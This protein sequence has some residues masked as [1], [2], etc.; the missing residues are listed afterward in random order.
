MLPA[1]VKLCCGIS[2]PHLR[3]AAGLQR[4]AVAVIG[5]EVSRQQHWRNLQQQT[6]E[7]A[8][9]SCDSGPSLDVVAKKEHVFLEQQGRDAMRAALEMLEHP[10]GWEVE[11]SETNGDRICSKLMPDARKV[12]RLDVVLDANMEEIYELL[13]VQVEQMHQWN[14]NIHRIKV[15]QHAGPETR[16]THEV[17]SQMAGNLIGQRDFLSVR[18]SL[19]T[20]SC[21]YLAGAATQLESCP[22]QAGYVRAEDG[23]TCI[24]I[25]P[26]R[27]E[28]RRSRFTWLLNMDV[29]GWLPKSIVNQSLPRAQ[30]EFI[31]HL[32]GR[33]AGM[34]TLG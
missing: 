13:F 26:L 33:L 18:H 15:L 6:L 11:I 3:S 12:F 2:Y 30:L 25:Q 9:L 19:R 27:G 1:V 22:P 21:I 14:P 34:D 31:R 20:K 28:S 4:T 10:E 32:R 16:V 29:K 24:I 8:H 7:H 5:H 23:P 17:S